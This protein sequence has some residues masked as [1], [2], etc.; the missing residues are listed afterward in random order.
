[1]RKR[2][3]KPCTGKTNN[4]MS[5]GGNMAGTDEKIAEIRAYANKL[6]LTALDLALEAGVEGA[7][8]GPAYSMAEITAT[9]FHGIMRHDPKK[10]ADPDRDHFILS[11]GHGVLGLYPLLE[12]CGYIT[13]EQ[14]KSFEKKD[15]ILV[16][17]PVHNDA[18]YI[19][20]STGSLGHGLSLGLGLALGLKK[21]GGAARVFVYMGD[22]ETNEGSV[23]EAAMMA[24]H[25]GAD[26]LLLVVD[27]NRLQSDGESRGIIDMGNMHAKWAAF[28]WEA[29]DCDGHNIADILDVTQQRNQPHGK[30][31]AVIARTVKGKGVSFFENDNAWHHNVL[32][33]E[34]YQAARDELL[35]LS[36][37]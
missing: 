34:K 4:L 19:D 31:L 1:M 36:V 13:M 26:N 12:Q 24:A 25:Q 29:R 11:K 3:P 32:T 23:W 33:P 21:K 14:L 9:L 27:H 2:L 22:G 30:P 8:L 35:K 20:F 5:F 10:Y 37:N 6:R 16:G 7:H 18:I 15:S 28:G 17:H